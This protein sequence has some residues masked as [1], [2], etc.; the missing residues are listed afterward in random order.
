LP[1]E[2]PLVHELGRPDEPNRGLREQLLECSYTERPE[3]EGGVFAMDIQV[4]STWDGAAARMVAISPRQTR[5]IEA[6]YFAI[7]S[8]GLG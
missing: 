3:L 7:G 2:A 5:P 8:S 6:A 4:M 1:I